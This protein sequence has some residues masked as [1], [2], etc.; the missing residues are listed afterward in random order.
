MMPSEESHSSAAR[1]TDHADPSHPSSL[2]PVVWRA[3]SR[4][5]AIGAVTAL[6]FCFAAGVVE[7]ARAQGS[8]ANVD[9][10]RITKA[11]Q[12]PA[13]W[14]TYGRTY[15]EQRFSPLARITADNVKQ[16]GLAWYADL[17]TNR[18]Q[19]ATPLVIDGVLYV[20][21]AWSMVKAFD[22]KTGAL[23][24]SYD[25]AVPRVLG[26]RG[27]CD[28]VNG[29]QPQD[30]PRVHPRARNSDVVRIGEEFCAA[31]D[32]LERR[33]GDYQSTECERL[34]PRLGSR[35][36]EGGL[37]CQLPWALERGHPHLRGRPRRPR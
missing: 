5:L 21:T 24:W 3:D 1:S 19:E 16:L 4:R 31:A 10:A 32:G 23:L 20:S 37:A 28:V 2:T 18:G 17:D 29:V 14:M 26:V 13:N 36:S 22:A 27:C 35:G 34:S 12:E 8:A 11:D 9:A 7:P 30:R 25:P 6:I 15:S 33:D